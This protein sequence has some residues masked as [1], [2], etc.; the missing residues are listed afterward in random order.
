MRELTREEAKAHQGILWGWNKEYTGWGIILW[1]GDG[2]VYY[3][4][5]S[6]TRQP[7]EVFTEFRSLEV[8]KAPDAMT[9]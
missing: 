4:D 9:S 1:M 6:S 2:W 8:P 3:R 7:D 5:I